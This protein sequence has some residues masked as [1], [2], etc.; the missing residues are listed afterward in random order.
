[1]VLRDLRGE[2]ESIRRSTRQPARPRARC[3][4]ASIRSASSM[5]FRRAARFMGNR[6][7]RLHDDAQRLRRR[8]TSRRWIVC[9]CT[10]KGRR[11]NVWGAGYSRTL[12]PRRTDGARGRPPALL[13]VPAR[14]GQGL[15]RRL[16]RDARAAPTTWTRCC[17]A[18]ASTG[19]RSACGEAGWRAS[20]RRLRRDRRPAACASGRKAP[21]LEFRRLRRGRPPR[22]PRGRRH[23]AA[24]D[25]RD[26]CRRI[27]SSLDAG[28]RLRAP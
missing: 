9:V 5:P 25:G 23:H 19:K 28:R 20:G 26:P 18:S 17:T 4:T 11:R 7:G 15:S 22:R 10:F 13:R 16:S 8:W 3:R 24:L 12:L 27:S 21:A 1:M 2:M 6:G 14:R